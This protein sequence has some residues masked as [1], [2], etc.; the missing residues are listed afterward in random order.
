MP[1]DTLE[2]ITQDMVAELLAKN[3]PSSTTLSFIPHH[4]S[5]S[6][7]LEEGE[8]FQV[9]VIGGTYY[10]CALFEYLNGQAH[11]KD[12]EDGTLETLHTEQTLLLFI[13]S[14]L[15]PSIRKLVVNFA[16]PLKPIVDPETQL[17]DGIL[18]S[19]SKEHK[20]EGLVGQAVGK[21][22]QEHVLASRAQEMSVAVTNDTICLLLSGLDDVSS[23]QS[24]AAAIVG[25]GVN[26]AYFDDEETA[27]NTEAGNFTSF[28]HPH[29]MKLVD[30][31]SSN[32]HAALYEKTVAGA[33][34][35]KLYN[36]RIKELDEM[37][38]SDLI[39]DTQQLDDI[40]RSC[41]QI[42]APIAQEV[43]TRSAQLVACMM[44]ALMIHK[45][46]SLT[47]VV[48]GSVFWRAWNYEDMV[49]ATVHKLAPDHTMHAIRVS[50]S[51][52]MGAAKL[53][54]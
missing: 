39:S 27:V 42:K 12:A 4:I 50:E 16:F 35:Y 6:R 38:E 10:K 2:Q 15:H 21:R 34:L 18:V 7:M 22:I 29:E 53:L 8:L 36:E 25:T 1:F 30:R 49:N 5:P 41:D 3:P 17:L 51:N 54:G 47:F 40:A 31:N 32:P 44:A 9:I 19:E 45:K 14:L 26:F 46:R 28:A 11:I 48:E 52:V 20:L 37:D 33:Y 13:E 24:L 43:L 23:H